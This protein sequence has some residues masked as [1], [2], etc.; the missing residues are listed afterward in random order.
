MQFC[1]NVGSNFGF[2]IGPLASGAILH[3]DLSCRWT[4]CAGGD[5]GTVGRCLR[6]WILLIACMWLPKPGL[7]QSGNSDANFH[8]GP[9]T[10]R[11]MVAL[12]L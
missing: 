4:A 9:L 3:V 7:A 10:A 11:D 6:I 1:D 12:L 2:K 8:G 5:G